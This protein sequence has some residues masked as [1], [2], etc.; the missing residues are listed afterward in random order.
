MCHAAADFL[1]PRSL[2]TAQWG[3]ELGAERSAACSRGVTTKPRH[4]SRPRL[5]QKCEARREL[6]VSHVSPYGD[7]RTRERLSPPMW[8]VRLTG[9]AATTYLTTSQL[10]AC[11]CQ[12]LSTHTLNPR[13]LSTRCARRNPLSF[14]DTRLGD[15]PGAR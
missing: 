11:R 6:L 4:E 9:A 5:E 15:V 1:L 10:S 14:N 13:D 8:R 12:S 3:S 7:A 2:P